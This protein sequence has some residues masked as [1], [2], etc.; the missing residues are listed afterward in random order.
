MQELG[1]LISPFA[2]F[3]RSA[4]PEQIHGFTAFFIKHLSLPL[5]EKLDELTQVFLGFALA[6]K[7]RAHF[8]RQTCS[9][10]CWPRAG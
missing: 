1:H 2:G 5:F 4:S 9:V 3:D 10:F 7:E 8:F 6:M